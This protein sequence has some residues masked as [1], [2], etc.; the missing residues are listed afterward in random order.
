LSHGVV[1]AWLSAQARDNPERL[2]Q[3]LALAVRQGAGRPT[4]GHVLLD[5][6]GPGGLEGITIWLAELAQTALDVVLFVDEAN[7]L[8]PASREALAYLLRNAPPNLRTVVA[9][10]PDCHLD[11][12]DLIAYGQCVVVGP[13]MLRLR[14]GETLEL[15]HGR[16]GDR[17]DNDTA[18]RL[19]ELTEGWPLGVQLAPD[20]D[21]IDRR[22]DQVVKRP[23]PHLFAQRP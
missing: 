10:R 20:L 15:V 19:H 14:L 13:A 18:A 6:V 7:R 1:V 9:A 4:F 16:F 5:A 23:G 21:A 8:P 3:G 2:A 17:V 22:V 12:D 11:I